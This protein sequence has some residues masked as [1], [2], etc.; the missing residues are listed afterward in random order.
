MNLKSMHSSS[1]KKILLALAGPCL[2]LVL[3]WVVERGGG[4]SQGVRPAPGLQSERATPDSSNPSARFADRDAIVVS[5]A[6]ALTQDEELARDEELA[7]AGEQ[8][9]LLTKEKYPEGF[10]G[11]S[12]EGAEVMLVKSI[13]NECNTLP[14]EL[15]DEFYYVTVLE[16]EGFIAGV[17]IARPGPEP[18]GAKVLS[19]RPV[20]PA[21]I[22]HNADTPH[23]NVRTRQYL[24]LSVSEAEELTQAK[25]I[26][27]V[28]I[29]PSQGFP[30]LEDW[31]YKVQGDGG[32][33]YVS[34][35]YGNVFEEGFE[36]FSGE[37]V[38]D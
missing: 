21:Y 30:D 8:A 34:M 5:R 16:I 3:F 15:A 28:Y 20:G 38:V 32:I 19:I 6:H 24:G 7:S 22:G 33:S 26:G 4:P 31:Y 2:L 1:G 13:E 14:S 23:G 25:V 35:L 18:D 10:P 29:C 37:S 12:F 9:L 36:D 11:V 17:V 27:E